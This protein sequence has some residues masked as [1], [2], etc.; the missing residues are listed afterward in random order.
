MRVRSLIL[1]L[2]AALIVMLLLVILRA[3]TTRLHYE[4]ST[5]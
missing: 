3:E 2:G 5:V 1:V 4:L